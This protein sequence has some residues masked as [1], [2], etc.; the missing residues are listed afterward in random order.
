MSEERKQVSS[1]VSTELKQLKEYSD[2]GI[3]TNLAGALERIVTAT[4]REAIP[5]QSNQNLRERFH[6]VARKFADKEL[7]IEPVL[8]SLVTAVTGRFSA[9]SLAQHNSMS[10]AVAVTLYEDA[11][12]RLRLERLWHQLRGEV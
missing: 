12:S 8:A 9:L 6:A 1:R 2:V 4:D 7:C 3:T 5:S 11:E 10:R